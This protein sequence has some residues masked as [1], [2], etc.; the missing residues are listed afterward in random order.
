MANKDANTRRNPNSNSGIY[1]TD[2]KVAQY[3]Q[4][5]A[6]RREMEWEIK[7]TAKKTATKK[8]HL[9]LNRSED[10]Y[11]CINFMNSMSSSTTDEYRF[12]QLIQQSYNTIKDAFVHIGGK[13]SKLNNQR[14]DTVAR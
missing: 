10:F 11:M 13:F 8:V 14:R 1:L 9:Q 4:V 12:I 2:V 5:D 7:I 3:K 6:S